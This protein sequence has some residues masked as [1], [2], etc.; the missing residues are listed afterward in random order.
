MTE[1]L[2]ANGISF[3][4]E[5][6]ITEAKNE[7]YLLMP[8]LQLTRD[9]R[10]ALEKA[11]A[12]C[13][14]MII[15]YSNEDLYPE[16]KEVLSR[17]KTLEIYNS[18]NLNARCCCNEDLVLITSMDLFKNGDSEII[19]MGILIRRESDPELYKKIYGEIK[20]IVNLSDNMNLHRRSAGE[21]GMPDVKIKKAYHGFCIKCAM[22]V[23]YNLNKL[24]CSGC[25]SKTDNNGE[26]GG[27]CHMCGIHS[28][29]TKE[30]P[31]CRNCDETVM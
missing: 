4:I 14:S 15:V 30:A 13:I 6:I 23:S 12:N 10:E 7:L 19:E 16:E 3:Y 8:Y 5:R 24:Y 31:L 2:T 27:Y 11:S 22:P 25:V 26:D 20:S 17:F 29:T 1:F 9:F 28:D 21:G 18:Q